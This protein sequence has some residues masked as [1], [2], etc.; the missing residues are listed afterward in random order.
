MSDVTAFRLARTTVEYKADALDGASAA[1]NGARWNAVNV[2]MVYAS[3]SRALSALETLV[4]L[5]EP[6][7]VELPLDRYLIEINIHE[8]AWAAR[9]IFN[10]KSAHDWDAIPGSKSAVDWGSTWAS[11]RRSLVAIVP[12]VIVPEEMNVLLNPLH[13]DAD[14]LKAKIMRKW[15]YD[16]R[17][18]AA[19]P[20]KP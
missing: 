12:S 2:P 11:K 15:L 17:I 18:G 10:P 13:P 8:A 20:R 9:E 19:H 16:P 6:P 3:L 4:H 14:G 5:A 7:G 1:H